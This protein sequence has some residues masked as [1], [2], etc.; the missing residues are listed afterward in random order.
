MST[1]TLIVS[2]GGPATRSTSSFA[3][4]VVPCLGVG[5]AR[6]ASVRFIVSGLNWK[7][8]SVFGCDPGVC[9]G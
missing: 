7:T 9:V 2:T 5:S 1:V 3:A 8:I 6:C 4:P